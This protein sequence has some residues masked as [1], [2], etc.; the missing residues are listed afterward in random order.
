LS[1]DEL[2]ARYELFTL[3]L[4]LQA[5]VCKD[6]KVIGSRL[7]IRGRHSN[8]EL[9]AMLKGEVFQHLFMREWLLESVQA[10]DTKRANVE[11]CR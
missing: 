9:R 1:P 10:G 5:E 7:Q 8:E 6:C 2:A 3:E 11:G 4:P